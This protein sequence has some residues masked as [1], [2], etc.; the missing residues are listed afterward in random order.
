MNAFQV[1]CFTYEGID[2]IK[3]A[4]LAGEAH[5]TPDVPIKIKVRTFVQM[6]DVIYLK[7]IPP[8]HVCHDHD[9]I[10]HICGVSTIFH[11][12]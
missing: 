12:Y 7:L 11:N 9:N 4:L 6:F 3:E 2:A 8:I 10:L 1:T 5:S